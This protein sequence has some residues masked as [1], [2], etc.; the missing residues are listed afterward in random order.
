LGLRLKTY[1]TRDEFQRL[2]GKHL[3]LGA[4]PVIQSLALGGLP[5]VNFL[6]AR[7]FPAA[8]DYGRQMRKI[9]QEHASSLVY[10][11]FASSTGTV[12]K[13]FYPPPPTVNAKLIAGTEQINTC[14][15]AVIDLAI[16]GKIDGWQSLSRADL[17]QQGEQMRAVGMLSNTAGRPAASPGIAAFKAYS[18]QAGVDPAP[19]ENTGRPWFDLPG[20]LLERL[21]KGGISLEQYRAAI[22]FCKL[23]PDLVAPT[24][25]Q[26]GK[27]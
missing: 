18:T 4:L 17:P 26:N 16:A 24:S 6:V 9:T 15:S 5:S 8:I 23:L 20:T 11:P 13:A 19:G 21:R 7:D 1:D 12:P 27:L 14:Y 22:R 10:A 25:G 3:E 2:S